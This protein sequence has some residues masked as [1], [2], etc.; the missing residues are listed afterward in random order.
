MNAHSQYSPCLFDFGKDLTLAARFS[1]MNGLQKFRAPMTTHT[2]TQ[3]SSI[4]AID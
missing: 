2:E 3:Y 1:T 4:V